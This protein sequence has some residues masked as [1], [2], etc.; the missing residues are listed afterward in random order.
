MTAAAWL[1]A[2]MLAQAAPPERGVGLGLFASSPEYDYRELLE[3]IADTGATHVC[4]V[5]VWWQDGVAATEIHRHGTWSA[6]DEQILATMRTARQLG[7]HVTAFPIVR[8]INGN[9]D[10]WRGKIAPVDEAKWWASYDRYILHSAGLAAKGGAQRLSV[11]SE[12][13]S[14]ESMRGRWLS[15]IDRVRIGTPSLELMY[16]ANWDHFQPVSFWDAVDVVGMTAYF[17]LTKSMKPT[18]ADLVKAWLPIRDELGRWSGALGRKIVITEI[19]YPSLDGAAA[20]PWDE[21][22]RARPDLAEQRVAYEAFIEAWAGA[23][24]LQGVYWWNW[25]GWGGP[26]D[27]GYTPRGKPAAK[28]IRR[29]YGGK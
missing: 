11:G 16:S 19:G 3:E 12:L 20:W 15:L 13:L 7:L 23:K 29:W 22:R 2:L 9:R 26:K 18:R 14:R 10:H 8:L 28:V 17:E 24:H 27:T 25:F 4:L 5:W 6:T 21:T 1:A